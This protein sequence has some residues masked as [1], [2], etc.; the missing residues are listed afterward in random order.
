ML[1]T[2]KFY[3]HY[4]IEPGNK[5]NCRIDKINCTGKIFLE[6]EHPNLINGNRYDFM[7][8][9]KEQFTDRK[10]RI[11]TNY[12]LKLPEGMQAHAI[13]NDNISLEVPVHIKATLIRTRKG[14]LIL[15]NIEVIN[16]C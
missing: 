14:I 7:I 5:I 15:N 9:D 3:K 16:N 4:G 8:L 13:L 11:Q 10:G 12:S 2:L 6:P 1:M